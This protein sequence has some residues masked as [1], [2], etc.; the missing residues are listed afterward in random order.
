M[1]LFR[2]AS[3]SFQG[4]F[5]LLVFAINL[6]IVDLWYFGCF[7]GRGVLSDFASANNKRHSGEQALAAHDTWPGRDSQHTTAIFR[8]ERWWH[9]RKLREREASYRTTTT[10]I[11]FKLKIYPL[12][13]CALYTTRFFTNLNLCEFI[14]IIHSNCKINLVFRITYIFWIKNIFFCNYKNETGQALSSLFVSIKLN[15][16]FL[17]LY[18]IIITRKNFTISTLKIL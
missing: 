14:I 1:L 8:R 12:F 18:M 9:W 5:I 10:I 3:P 15:N 17:L 4:L 13:F 16:P 2:E 11:L 6:E 7:E